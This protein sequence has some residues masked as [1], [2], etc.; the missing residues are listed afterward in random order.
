MDKAIVKPSWR[1]RSVELFD[2]YRAIFGTSLLLVGLFSG[3]AFSADW[4]TRS[5][6]IS[7]EE[8]VFNRDLGEFLLKNYPPK[9]YLYVGVGRSPTLLSAHLQLIDPKLVVNLP[10]SKVK[11]G[12]PFAQMTPEQ[13][14]LLKEH[15]IRFLPSKAELAGRTLLLID[16][17]HSGVGLAWV[18]EYVNG[19]LPLDHRAESLGLVY[20]KADPSLRVVWRQIDHSY[21]IGG[22]REALPLYTQKYDSFAAFT[23]ADLP[24]QNENDLENVRPNPN[25]LA[26]VDTLKEAEQ[27][28]PRGLTCGELLKAGAEFIFKKLS[29]RIEYEM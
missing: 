12:R 17:V 1:R 8:V 19:L 23:P 15:L 28:Y 3:V 2:T 16:F 26:L 11:S 22:R 18:Q 24:F 7:K 4:S 20:A 9:K 25:Y 29:T 10:A 6:E 21:I 14:A 27:K 5:L 13:K